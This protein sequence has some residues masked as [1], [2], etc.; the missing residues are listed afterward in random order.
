MFNIEECIVFLTNRVSKKMSDAVNEHFAKFGI[1]RV[2]W[3]EM[4][5]LLKYG[6]MNQTELADKMDIKDST[7]VRLV[8]RMEKDQYLVRDKDTQDRRIT[9]LSLTEK[10]RTRIEE[11]LPEGEMMSCAFSRGISGEEFGVFITVLN[12][13]MKNAEI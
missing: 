8:D 10:G 13:L 12:K 3:I 4:Y 6:R 1:T 9:F 11:L 7:V 5:Y 2:Q